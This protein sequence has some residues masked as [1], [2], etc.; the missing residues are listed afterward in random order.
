[1]VADTMVRACLGALHSPFLWTVGFD[2]IK[3]D[4]GDKT[5]VLVDSI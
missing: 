3:I 2:L 4:D 5:R 1:M